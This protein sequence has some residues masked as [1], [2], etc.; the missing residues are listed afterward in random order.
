MKCENCGKR[1]ATAIVWD[2]IETV[3]A[4]GICARKIKAIV[5]KELNIIEKHEYWE[6]LETEDDEFI[7]QVSRQGG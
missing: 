7:K 6:G 5:R 1:K 3:N 4:C 2:G